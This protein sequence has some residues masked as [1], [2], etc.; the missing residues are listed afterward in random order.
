MIPFLCGISMGLILATVALKIAT[1]YI[2]AKSRR[3]KTNA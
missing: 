3:R 2:K 1:V